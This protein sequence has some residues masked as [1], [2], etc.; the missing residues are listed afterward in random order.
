MFMP[1]IS[2][3]R[4][5]DLL[6]D[7][8]VLLPTALRRKTSAQLRRPKRSKEMW[9]SQSEGAVQAQKSWR[10]D[11]GWKIGEGATRLERRN[12]L[13]FQA[14]RVQDRRQNRMIERC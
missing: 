9:R 14:A 4:L 1:F 8:P 11:G 2:S 12:R 3:I 7:K 10:A 5:S 6:V 13:V